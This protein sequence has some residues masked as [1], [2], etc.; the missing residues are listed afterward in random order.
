VRPAQ[1]IA[2]T[3]ELVALGERA[4]PFLVARLGTRRTHELLEVS[5]VLA[6]IGRPATRALVRA[7]AAGDERTRMAAARVLGDY[8]DRTSHGPLVNALSDASPRVRAAAAGALGE[9]G[10]PDALAPLSALLA[11]ERS[12]RPSGTHLHGPRPA[13]APAA[14]PPPAGLPDDPGAAATVLRAACHAI[15]RLLTRHPRIAL[16]DRTAVNLAAL[17]GDADAGV[18]WTAAAALERAGVAA[19]PRLW[20]LALGPASPASWAAALAVGRILGRHPAHRSPAALDAYRRLLE[21]PAAQ[22]RAQAVQA[23][24]AWGADGRAMALA[25]LARERHPLVRQAVL[26]LAS[27]RRSRAAGDPGWP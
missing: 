24:S 17:V 21:H 14:S 16:G 10:R 23:L 12:E 27:R 1:R 25:R 5:G 4:V 11:R 2:A 22:T 19:L 3:A 15:S 26:E 18:R 9:R 20:P 7:L 8:A 6:R 13:A